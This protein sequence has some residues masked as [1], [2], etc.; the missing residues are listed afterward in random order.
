MT[1]VL[2]DSGASTCF[3]NYDSAKEIKL[4]QTERMVRQA[5]SVVKTKGSTVGR[6]AVGNK[7]VEDEFLAIK[8]LN[9]SAIIGLSCLQKAGLTMD[10]TNKTISTEGWSTEIETLEKVKAA[11]EVVIDEHDWKWI[12]IWAGQTGILEWRDHY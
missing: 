6:V 1:P 11:E 8:N 3:V 4:E 10:F 12:K 9:Y 2:V 7:E 5:D